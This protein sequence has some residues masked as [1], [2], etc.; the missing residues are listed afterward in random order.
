[1]YIFLVTILGLVLRLTFIVKPEGLWNDEYVSW[2]VA[3]T[4]FNQGFWQEVLKQCHMPLYYLYLKP[5]AQCS[6]L[7]LRLTS[8]LPSFLAI[9]IMYLVGKEYSEKCGKF[10][11]IATAV[12]PFLIYYAQ[13]VRFYSLVFVLSALVLLF[14]IKIIKNPDPKSVI[15]YSAFSCILIFTHVLGV[16]YILLTTLLLLYKLKKLSPKWLF[17]IILSL[18]ALLPFGLNILKQLPSSQW[19]GTFSYTNIL[20]L[21]SDFLSPILTNNVNAPP[22]FFYKK[23]VLFVLLLTVPTLIGFGGIFCRFKKTAGLITISAIFVLTIATL[24]LNGKLVFITKYV[25]EILPVLILAISVGF[26]GSN[27]KLGKFKEMLFYTFVFINLFAVFTPYYPSKAI[28]SEGHRLPAIILNQIN[29][30]NILYT[31][32][33]PDRFTRYVK[34]DSKFYHISKINRFDYLDNPS[35]ILD[36]IK[37]GESTAIV[38]LDS[39]SFIPQNLMEEAE[40]KNFPEM[41]I[42]FSK[43]RYSLEK[44]FATNFKEIYKYKAGSWT[45]LCGIKK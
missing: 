14:T 42:T 26:D 8:V 24:A 25:I 6:D 3:S 44:S 11:A 32:Y 21:F 40:S 30:N 5:F 4:P 13:E 31:Y 16:F 17:I 28:R 39:V 7:V 9:P 37:P 15:L 41:F 12:L 35:A 20:F 23:E 34:T 1:M 2:F 19:W 36:N 29:P 43:I 45:V 18:L 27:G 10:C 33:A 22:V 38:F